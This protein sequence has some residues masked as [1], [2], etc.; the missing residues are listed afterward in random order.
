MQEWHN[1]Y[2]ASKALEVTARKYARLARVEANLAESGWNPIDFPTID[3]CKE[4]RELAFKDQQL[5]PK[6]WN[7]IKPKLEPLVQRNRDARLEVE[8][9]RRRRQRDE[10]ISVLYLQTARETLA[11]SCDTRDLQPY[12]PHK[13]LINALPCVEALFEADI[14]TITGDKWLEVVDE[15]CTFIRRHWRKILKQIALVVETGTAPPEGFHNEVETDDS[16]EKVVEDI[17]AITA[18]LARVSA[19]FICKA[20][21]CKEIH[22]FPSILTCSPLQNPSADFTGTLRFCEPLGAERERLVNRMLVDLGLDV[23]NTTKS[24]VRHYIDAQ[25]WFSA[26]QKAKQTSSHSHKVINDHDWLSDDAPLVRQDD[27]TKKMMLELAKAAF[28]FEATTD[29]T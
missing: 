19:A 23:E 4:F 17:D 20:E 28:R 16:E 22:W 9:A 26:V 10:A 14:E 7:N 29:P 18:K 15:V 11:L 21:S 6:I 3:D 24:D 5:T 2:M 12:F 1:G 27:L 25:I 8:R 13:R